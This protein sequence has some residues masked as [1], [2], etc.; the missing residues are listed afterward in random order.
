MPILRT[1][2]V[3]QGFIP[4]NIRTQEKAVKV[5]IIIMTCPLIV[6]YHRFS[7]DPFTVDALEKSK[8]L[9]IQKWLRILKIYAAQT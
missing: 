2:H 5:T 6:W 7:A 8:V 3:V 9:F 4:A 1:N